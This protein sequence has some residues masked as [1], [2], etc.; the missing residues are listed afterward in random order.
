MFKPITSLIIGAIAAVMVPS[1]A[2]NRHLGERKKAEP[3]GV[4]TNQLVQLWSTI[5]DLSVEQN[6]FP[7]KLADLRSTSLSTD[8][9]V[10]PGTGSRPGS[11]AS[12]EEWSD[13]IYI[14]GAWDGVPDCALIISPPENHGDEYGYIVCVDGHFF[15][16]PP[17]S[18]RR[19]IQEPWRL[20]DDASPANID[21]LKQCLWLRVPKRLQQYY[22]PSRRFH[23]GPG[24]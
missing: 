21:Y 11:L 8:L 7:L 12:V 18:V 10:C 2:A 4:I 16:L 20:D 22:G 1:C 14:G 3:E 23:A 17:N 9:L 6:R 19:T 13:F 15:R 5:H 24:A